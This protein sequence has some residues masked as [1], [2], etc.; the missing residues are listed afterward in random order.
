[1]GYEHDTTCHTEFSVQF[2]WTKNSKV[3]NECG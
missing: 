3:F 1:V 2:L